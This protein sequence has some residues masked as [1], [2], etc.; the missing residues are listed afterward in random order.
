MCLSGNFALS[1]MA[2]P[3]VHAS[4][5]AQP[6]LPILRQDALHMSEV[7]LDQIRA[8]IDAKGPV[9]AYRFAGDPLC[10]S[11]RFRALDNALN[12]PEKTRVVLHTLPGI[13][14]GVLTTDF[15]DQEGHPTWAARRN[16]IDYFQSRLS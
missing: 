10:T 14:H 3:V 12:T 9:H 6:S 13:G 5:S 15:V 11:R 1:L 7:D 2:E 4:V 16:V 8:A